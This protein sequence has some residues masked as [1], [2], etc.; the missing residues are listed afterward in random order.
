MFV[1]TAPARDLAAYKWHNRLLLLFAP[2]QEDARL[3]QQ[4]K[5]LQS[6]T[7]NLDD[8]DFRIFTIVEKSPLRSRFQVAPDAFVV[9]LV[10]KD[11]TEKLRAETVVEAAKIFNL[12]DSMP[13]RQAGGR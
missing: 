11:G 12:V 1:S 2:S 4:H 10:G 7:K 6:H 5:L 8:R 9:I 13:M 3:L